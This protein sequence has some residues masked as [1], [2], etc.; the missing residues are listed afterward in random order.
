MKKTDQLI[1]N[2]REY[3]KLLKSSNLTYWQMNF[4]LQQIRA[5]KQVLALRGYKY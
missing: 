1:W 3:Q 4:Y 5:I 2:L